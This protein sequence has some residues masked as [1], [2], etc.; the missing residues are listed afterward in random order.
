MLCAIMRGKL[1]LDT[2][3]QIFRTQKLK[4]GRENIFFSF[5]FWSIGYSKIEKRPFSVMKLENI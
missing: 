5:S 1:S 4:M 3:Y 2:P